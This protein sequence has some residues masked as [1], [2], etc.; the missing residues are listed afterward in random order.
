VKHIFRRRRKLTRTAGILGAIAIIIGLGWFY[1]MSTFLSAPAVAHLRSKIPDETAFMKESPTPPMHEYVPISKISPYL[2]QAV[3]I[4]EDD[5][6]FTHNAVNWE[7]A[8]KAV[9]IDWKRKKFSHGASTITMQLAR[10]LYLSPGKSLFRKSREILIA[11][12]LERELT[13]ERILEIYLNVVEWG[14]GIFGA[15]AAARHYFGKSAAALTKHE[16]AFLAAILPRPVYYD[17]HRNGEY[18]RGRIRSI[19]ERL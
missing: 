16:S 8:W 6:F 4:A 2:R 7:A 18:L 12:K 3:V 13:K 19:E 14:D 11:W 9:K 17:G 10:N 5:L 1:E 15:E